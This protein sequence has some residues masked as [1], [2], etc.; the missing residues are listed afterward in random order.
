MKE[1]KKIKASEYINL[2]EVQHNPYSKNPNKLF[3][4]LKREAEI[5]VGSGMD[6]KTFS[7]IANTLSNKIKK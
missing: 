4:I 7:Q 5:N 6:I 3:D 1:Y 2:L